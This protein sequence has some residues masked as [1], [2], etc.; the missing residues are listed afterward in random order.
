MIRSVKLTLKFNTQSKKNKIIALLSRY[1]SAV[2]F[3]INEIWKDGTA[4]LNKETLARL[5]NT[6]L[7]ERYKSQALKH[8]IDIC[9]STRKAA[10][11]LKTKASKPVFKGA[12]KLDSKFIEIK[13]IKNKEFDICIRLSS[14][15]NRQK[16]N[17]V[18]KKTVVFNKWN[19]FEN[20]TLKQGCF[21]S[22]DFIIIFFEISEVT[23][24]EGEIKA[25]DIGY[26]HILSTSDREFI[27]SD[28][29]E[30]ILTKIKRKKKGSNS[31][32]KTYKERENFINQAVN[33]LN[34]E[35]IKVLGIEK[36]V[37]LKKGKSKKRSKNFRKA[38]SGWTYRHV[39]NRIKEKAQENRVLLVE[40]NPRYTSQI[41]PSCNHLSKDNR[42]GEKFKCVSCGYKEH[43]DYVGALNILARTLEYLQEFRVPVAQKGK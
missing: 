36:I 24:S 14:L 17:L 27:G 8:A 18:S 43:A 33:K 5:Q 39:I 29:K 4:S 38:I 35:S 42:K 19:N 32:H 9:S 21:L 28:F 13:E 34:F 22:E 7:S 41:C 16:L 3:Y 6:Q 31:I 25:L 23:K 26:N 2:N 20:S 15:K 40:V 30:K 37:N 10:K 12:A 1:R 11:A